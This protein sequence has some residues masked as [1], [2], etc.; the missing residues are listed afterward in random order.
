MSNV[1]LIKQDVFAETSLK[2]SI[3]DFELSYDEGMKNIPQINR[4]VSPKNRNTD[5]NRRFQYNRL[6]DIL[7]FSL[8]MGTQTKEIEP[9]TSISS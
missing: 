9:L 4:Q 1:S 3:L 2:C 7:K 5:G 6:V 8:T